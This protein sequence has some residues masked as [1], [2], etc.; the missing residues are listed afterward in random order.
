MTKKKRG[1][2][3]PKKPE[4]KKVKVAFVYVT[5]GEKKKI[6]SKYGN[7]TKAIRSEV[8]PKCG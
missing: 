5:T 7:I 4:N 2:G 8:L 3:A 1:R 6:D